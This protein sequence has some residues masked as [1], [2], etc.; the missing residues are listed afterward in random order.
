MFLHVWVAQTLLL[1]TKYRYVNMP[2]ITFTSF[3]TGAIF[4]S[5]LLRGDQSHSYKQHPTSVVL[6]TYEISVITLPERRHWVTFK[7]TL[8]SLQCCTQHIAP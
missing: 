7:S 3:V 1:A 8:F 4:R 6:I 5:D 2:L